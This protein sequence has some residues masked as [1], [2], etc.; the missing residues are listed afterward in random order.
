MHLPAGLNLLNI[1]GMGEAGPQFGM[2][3]YEVP[4]LYAA[5]ALT[6]AL[7]G[8]GALSVDERRGSAVGAPEHRESVAA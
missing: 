4:L 5:A 6:L 3:G 2:P 7:G 8:P 1:T